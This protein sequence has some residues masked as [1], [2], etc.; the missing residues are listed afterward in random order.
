MTPLVIFFRQRKLHMLF[1]VLLVIAVSSFAIVVPLAFSVVTD[2]IL[3]Q[4]YVVHFSLMIG[5]LLA[6]VAVRM[7]A[8]FAQD[9][10]FM[11]SRFLFEKWV[12]W[13]VMGKTLHARASAPGNAGDDVVARFSTFITNFQFNFSELFYFLLYSLFVSTLVLLILAYASIPFLALSL[14]FLGAHYL[15]LI[16]HL[17]Q[18]K[19]LSARYVDTKNQM[20]ARIGNLLSSKKII[21]VFGLNRYVES[22]LGKDTEPLYAA[23]YQREL[24]VNRQELIQSFLKNLLFVLL[25]LVGI[26]AV[27]DEQLTM[28]LVLLCILLV[29]FVYDPIY[30]LNAITKAYADC[31]AQ[32]QALLGEACADKN[33]ATDYRL[34]TLPVQDLQRIELSGVSLHRGQQALFTGINIRLE[35]GKIYLIDGPSG[36]GKSSLLRLIAGLESP[37]HG[38]ALW[39][40]IAIPAFLEKAYPSLHYCPQQIYW[41]EAS[42][43]DNLGLFAETVNLESIQQALDKASCHFAN[44]GFSLEDSGAR[45]WS[46]GQLRR[47]G[48]ARAFYSNASVLLLDEPTANLDV[49]T[50]RQILAVLREEAKQKIVVLCTHSPALKLLADVCIDLQKGSVS[51]RSASGKSI[52]GRITGAA[53]NGGETG[54]GH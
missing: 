49:V 5:L 27:L 8:N 20:N 1:L 23:Y 10:F 4:G 7:L 44:T 51:E 28:A 39:N 45:N 30:R 18:A 16:A 29:G 32:L 53:V 47:L 33:T 48:L 42:L 9:Y 17:G 15:N 22:L 36:T 46:G 34:A 6:M 26:V 2:F 25:L 24:V 14:V 21:N 19:A 54:H 52:E 31:K 37:S 43:V 13:R 50:E 38:K 40:G 12:L 35:P 41:A 11:K 3:P